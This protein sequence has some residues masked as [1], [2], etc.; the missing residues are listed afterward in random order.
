MKSHQNLGLK[1]VH[2]F[3]PVVTH[4]DAISNHILSLRSILREWGMLSEIISEYPQPSFEAEAQHFHRYRRRTTSEDVI[5]LHFSMGY[6]PGVMNWVRHIRGRK[7][8][9][10]HNITPAEYFIGVNGVYRE[11]AWLG[12]Q[13]LGR[14]AT[15]VSDGWGDSTYNCLELQ[16]AGIAETRVL[17]I[18]I[19]P[20]FYNVPPDPEL[21]RRLRAEPGPVVLFVGRVVPNKR[22]EDVIL[23]FHYL[24][25]YI[26]PTAQLYFVGSHDQ[27]EPY[28]D[29]L[30]T[31]VARLGLPDV[32]F[33]GH[34]SKEELVAFYQ[35]ADVF[36]C[37]SEHEGFGVPLVE[38]MN[39]G[40]PVVA[41]AAAAVPE[42]MG[43]AGVL[44]HTKDPA[45]VAELVGVLLEDEAWRSRIVARQRDRARDFYPESVAG[46]LADA[47]GALR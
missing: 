15:M 4:G 46:I 32:H 21:L 40:L 41:Y 31:L 11:V 7:I 3:H 9:V 16:A 39:Y 17:P 2:Q 1:T 38:S 26:R 13:Q 27:M 8:L 23:T 14:L 28:L 37:M 34:V 6:S 19:D 42:T 33:E 35:G 5:L 12:R 44:V 22:L 30:G 29:Y 36:L 18:V 45:Y 10:Y 25:R 24:K 43:D 47:L 20:G